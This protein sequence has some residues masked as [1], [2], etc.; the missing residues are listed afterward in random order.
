MADVILETPLKDGTTLNLPSLNDEQYGSIDL[1][2]AEEYITQTL[3]QPLAWGYPDPMN[4]FGTLGFSLQPL[5]RH[6]ARV[7]LVI[8]HPPV[9][10]DLAMYAWCYAQ[11]G[12]KLLIDKNTVVRPYIPKEVHDAPT[13]TSAPGVNGMEVA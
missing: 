1:A 6:T 5:N 4:H 12:L 11:L 2:K 8:D 13:K 10:N 7:L 3:H 9:L